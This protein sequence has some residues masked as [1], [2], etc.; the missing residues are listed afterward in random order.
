[1]GSSLSPIVS[2]IFMEDL[3]A[4]ALQ[5]SSWKPKMWRRYVND[6]F[7]I[8][9]QGDQLLEEFHRHLNELNPSIQFLIEKETKGNIAFLDVQL[10]NKDTKV[11]TSVF[12][13]KT[14]MDRYLNFESNH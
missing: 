6:V 13:K 10:E 14:H 4:Q 5:T 9:S 7:V 11:H 2:N 8:W 1:M 12:H 3:E